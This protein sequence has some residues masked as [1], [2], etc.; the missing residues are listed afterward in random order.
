[1]KPEVRDI[2]FVRKIEIYSSGY[3]KCCRYVCGL[4]QLE[5]GFTKKFFSTF[6]ATSHLVEDFLDYHGAKNNSRWFFYRELAAAVRHIGL[7]AYAQQHISDRFAFYGV[8]APAGFRTAGEETLTY[9]R[10]TLARLAPVI[11]KEAEK[12]GIRVPDDAF[13]TEDF[14]GL[15]TTDRLENDIEDERMGEQR[16]HVVK[17]A[18][19]FLNIAASFESYGFYDPYDME[20]IRKLVPEQVNEVEVRRVEMLVHNLQSAF[21][22][23]VIH[24]GVQSDVSM[25]KQFRGYVSVILHLLQMIGRLLHFYERHLHQVSLKAAYRD[26]QEALVDLIEPDILLEQTVNYALRHV[27]LFMDAGRKLARVL[28]KENVERSFIRTGI[29]MKRGFHS[30][31]S[32][33]V[34]KIV[35]YFG[36]QV[37]LCVGED[38]FDAGSVLDIQW[39]GGKIQKED[40]R[41]VVFEGDAR[42]LNDIQILASVNFGEDTMGKGIPLPSELSYL[43][44]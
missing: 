42:A 6:I 35:Q 24:G 41:E 34:A 21:D 39:A 5:H 38:R 31:P 8:S 4:S 20:T 11:L 23:Y 37:E 36:G 16:R 18:N 30:R 2:S 9:L 12:R 25:L 7:G 22:T 19:D 10:N 29:P 40:I 28:L 27:W 1:M 3:L 26:V 33:L 13:G 43:Q 32:L 44:S 15:V 14:P 17:I